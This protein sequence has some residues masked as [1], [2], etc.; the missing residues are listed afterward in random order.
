MLNKPYNV[1]DDMSRQLKYVFII[2]PERDLFISFTILVNLDPIVKT[3]F[4]IVLDFSDSFS[5]ISE[6]F[7]VSSIIPN[8]VMIP[9]SLFC[10]LN[11]KK[12]ME[13]YENAEILHYFKILFVK[14]NFYENAF[15]I[16]EYISP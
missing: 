16:N 11:Y 15:E 12:A 2:I 13:L 10:S 7:V 1:P 4:S 9:F 14:C 8:T 6:H 5:A 3:C